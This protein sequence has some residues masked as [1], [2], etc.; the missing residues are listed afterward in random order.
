MLTV[1]IFYY[2][3]W[4]LMM[5]SNLLNIVSIHFDLLLYT[6]T[7]KMHDSN[8]FKELINMQHKIYNKS[9]SYVITYS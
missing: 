4:A 3:S 2:I 9:M 7:Q 1:Y 8:L 6:M 5:H